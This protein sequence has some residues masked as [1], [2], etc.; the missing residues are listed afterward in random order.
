MI[1]TNRTVH[2]ISCLS[3]HEGEFREKFRRNTKHGVQ[4]GYQMP[5]S[6]IRWSDAS[7]AHLR[8]RDGDGGHK[9]KAKSDKNEG[10]VSAQ[11]SLTLPIVAF[12]VGATVMILLMAAF[13]IYSW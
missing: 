10:D 6:D 11:N 5:S 4:K 1:T 7:M 13:F 12:V 2:H 3:F 8:S 9:K